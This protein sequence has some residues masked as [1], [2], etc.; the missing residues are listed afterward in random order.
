[1]TREWNLQSL[2]RAEIRLIV[3]HEVRILQNQ[4]LRL[5]S[6]FYKL[7]VRVKEIEKELAA[8]R[9]ELH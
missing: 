1:M 3:D 4:G 5:G 2:V 8:H 9:R 6:D 7:G